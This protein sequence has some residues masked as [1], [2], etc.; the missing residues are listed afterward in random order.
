MYMVVNM[1]KEYGLIALIIIMT[2]II[3]VMQ[4]N[5][6]EIELPDELVQSEEIIKSEMI[7]IEIEGAVE[8]PGV[9]EVEE[10]M[11]INELFE[12][13]DASNGNQSCYNLAQKLVDEQKIVVPSKGEEC[14]QQSSV[15]DTGIVNINSASVY[16]LQSLDGIGESRAQAII[17]YRD[18]N[19]SFTS[20]DELTNVEG[21]SQSLVQQIEDDISLS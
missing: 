10:G 19:G 4:N 14:N 15:S 17:E 8:K 6:D 5:N 11:R 13:V 2:G 20:K 21:V 1:K 9:Y 7:V 12:M 16:D 3:I 18:L